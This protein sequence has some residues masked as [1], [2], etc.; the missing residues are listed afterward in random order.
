[1]AAA[2]ASDLTL[3]DIR[4]PWERARDDPAGPI[5]W[6]LPLS[7]LMQGSTALPPEG[8]YLIVCAHGVRS[9]ALAGHLRALGYPAVYS[10][11]GGLAAVSA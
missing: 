10:L 11:A 5:E 1:M 9:L 8:R 3:V 2:F 6:H 7:A 4:E